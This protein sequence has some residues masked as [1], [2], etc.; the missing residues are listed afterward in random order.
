MSL[1]ALKA[2]PTNDRSLSVRHMEMTPV[3]DGGSLDEVLLE[4]DSKGGDKG[5]GS[6]GSFKLPA[7]YTYPSPPTPSKSPDNEREPSTTP[8]GGGSSTAPVKPAPKEIIIDSSFKDNACLMA[9]Y[10]K[11]GGSETF[12]KYLKKF[13]K[14]MSVADLR[15]SASSLPP[16]THAF[17]NEPNNYLIEIE[18]NLNELN[19]TGLDVARTMI[20]EMIHAEMY[21]KLL[22]VVGKPNI[23]WTKETIESTRDS[24]PGIADYYTRWWLD[25]PPNVAPRSPQHEAMAQHYRTIIEMALKEFDNSYPDKTY[26]DL[27]WVGLMGEGQISMRTGLPSNPTE[28]WKNMSQEKRLSIIKTWKDLNKNSNGC[29]L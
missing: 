25:L 15:F 14:E 9:V 1:P 8:G 4:V 18:F 11:M 17:T 19:R 23:P 2:N 27:A 7:V 20:H 16:N 26:K 28:A 5:S 12:N 29:E 13:D 3:L 22:S 24:F 10:N 6:R 21:R